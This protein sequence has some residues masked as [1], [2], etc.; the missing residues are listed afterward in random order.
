MNDLF[1]QPVIGIDL[2]ASYTKISYR[3]PWSEGHEPRELRR[4]V[5]PSHLVPIDGDILVP[6]LVIFTKK[7]GWICGKEAADYIP[8]SQD[9]V[10]Q[11]W[12]SVLFSKKS[13]RQ[14]EGALD[15]ASSFFSWLKLKLDQ[16][17]QGISV[18]QSRVKV[19]LPAFDDI[20]EPAE[21]LANKMYRNG[22]QNVSVSRLQE[23][24]ANT[25]GI[26]SE[27]R[28]NLWRQF[29]HDDP[30]PVFL[31]IYE[32]ASPVLKHFYDSVMIGTS[33]ILK[34]AVVDIGSFTTDISLL[35]F[36][37][38]SGGDCINQGIQKSFEIGVINGYEKPLFNK[39]AE[40][41]NMQ[42][43]TL[44]FNSI[45][46]IKSSISAER[47][48]ILPLPQGRVLIGTSGDIQG[49]RD[50]CAKLAQAIF[51]ALISEA[52]NSSIKIVLFTGGGLAI[53][54]LKK[55][56]E[57]RCRANHIIPYDHFGHPE[58]PSINS[59]KIVTW[60]SSSENLRRI[61]TA[62]GSTSVL[63]DLPVKER[64]PDNPSVSIQSSYS[65]CS[66][67]GGNKECMR[68]GGTGHYRIR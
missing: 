2:G 39:L 68:C 63:L 8:T 7:R 61:A 35:E 37:S 1:S 45:E 25:L 22:W 19:C 51:Q 55:H 52:G 58:E 9:Q 14:V 24:R 67:N 18:E 11:N 20:I 46:R 56:L 66:C 33:P 12:K 47:E 57:E 50:I 28:N 30:N 10:F 48:I 40:S 41:R 5:Y 43:Q 38:R 53:K 16:Q 26:F 6:S 3:A 36:D 27:G 34:I 65:I 62:I 31:E 32:S 13:P 64:I 29:P 23:P 4:Y 21:I 44:S 42:F 49:S 15:A 60:Q 17:H 59:K 54:E